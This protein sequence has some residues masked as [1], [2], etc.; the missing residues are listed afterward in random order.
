V[1][2]CVCVLRRSCRF[3]AGIAAIMVRRMVS[4]A[5]IS[6]IDGSNRTDTDA[7]N[8]MVVGNRGDCDDSSMETGDRDE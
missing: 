2:V 8:A 5:V 4:S 1:Y 6:E 7:I 3:F